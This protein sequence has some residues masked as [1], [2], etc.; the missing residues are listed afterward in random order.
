MATRAARGREAVALA[1]AAVLAGLLVA[2]PTEEA[3]ATVS[4]QDGLIAFVGVKDNDYDVYV[5]DPDT[6]SPENLTQTPTDEEHDPV[7]SPSGDRLAFARSDA[8]FD[9]WVMNA[10]GSGALN[11]TPG[12]NDGMG[13]SGRRPAWSPDGSQI[14][15][16]DGGE[17]WVMDADGSDKHNLT[18][19]AA[20]TGLEGDPMYSPDGEQIAYV[21]GLDLWVMDADGGNQRLLVGS[22]AAERSPDWSPDGQTLVY[23]RS[24]EIWQ[25]DADGDGAQALVTSAQGGGT[26]P[27]YSPQGAHIAFS[28]SG[29]GSS[30]GG[31]DIVVA[32]ADGADPDRATGTP[33]SDL[34]PS[35]QPFVDTVDLAVTAVDTPDPVHVG[36]PV[37]YTVTV[38]NQTPGRDARF[39]SVAL[40]VPSGS[41]LDSVS[42]AQGTCKRRKST[43]TC[44]LG[45]LPGG[46]STAVTLV[47]TPSSTFDL[48]LG[49]SVSA[50]NP[51]PDP[52][53]NSFE[54]GTSVLPPPGAEPRALVTWTV[55][56]RFADH[57]GDGL[58]DENR[59]NNPK[60]ANVPFEMVLHG[61]DSSPVGTIT[62]Y[63]FAVTLPNGQVLT[64]NSSSCDFAFQPP[65]EG[66][67]P[68]EL[69][70]T[71]ADGQK[72]TTQRDVP[73]RDYLIVSLGDS[74]A[75]GEGNP[76]RIC[77]PLTCP[78]CSTPETWQDRPCHR[79]SLSG[80]SQAARLIE[81]GDPTTSVT[82]VHLACSGAQVTRGILYAWP[83]IEPDG[84]RKV[85]PQADVL[86]QLMKGWGRKPDAVLVSIGA[87]DAE[88]AE[89][90]KECLDLR[91]ARTTRIS[92]RLSRTGCP[93]LP[94]RYREPRRDS[95]TTWGSAGR[96]CSSPS[97]P[98]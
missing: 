20:G 9:I 25:V 28:S 62:N 30:A 12:A 58:L 34:E 31:P 88:F 63:R 77:L 35:W 13:N 53:N 89:A 96:R 64:Q 85:P 8:H 5:A 26:A 36:E 94:V 65:K 18:G 4:G 73:F 51:D 17:I 98:T 10:D 57:D 15:Y 76:D 82:F 50:G 75:S 14:A 41:S 46:T 33:L 92:C 79:S 21:R 95:W 59:F 87:N 54:E 69:E 84:D 68:V 37:T 32:G 39:A 55:P 24:G 80:P 42:A 40:L 29:F 44:A 1:A 47:V 16:E 7:W 67:Y 93:G 60:G 48:S 81:T 66:K 74:I 19:T 70:I 2:T 38:T 27:T 71:T 61:C 90:V 43:L 6:G 49:G 22:T 83:G 97:T 86:A 3:R 72:M 52:G 78:P 11:L 23:E 45:T 56:D 91:A